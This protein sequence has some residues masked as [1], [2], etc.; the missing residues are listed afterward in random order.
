[1][2]RSPLRPTENRRDWLLPILSLFTVTF[3]VYR[4]FDIRMLYGYA[5]L[6]LILGVHV[7][8][9][10]WDD[11]A[12]AL[13]PIRMALV[14]LALAVLVNFLRPDSHHNSDSLSFII[15]MVICCGFAVLSR[16]T[17]KLARITLWV[18]FAGAVG[19][20]AFIH[21]FQLNPWYFWNWFMMKVSD[22]AA[23]YTAYYIPKGYSFTLG[24]CT[25]TDYTLFLGLAVC[26]AYLVCGRKFDW[27]SAV[28]AGL[29][30]VFFYSILIVGRRGELLGAAACLAILVLALCNKKQ[31]RVLIVGGIIAAA[32]GF[33]AVV[34]LMPWL[35]QI[36]ALHRYVW[37]VEWMLKGYDITSGRTELYALAW[38]AFLANPLF[39]LGW[40]NFYT[41]I[42]ESFQSLHGQNIVEDVHNIYLQFLAE[43]GIVGTPFLIAPLFYI[44]WQVVRQFSRL[45]GCA[46]EL[47]TARMFCTVSFLIQ[48]FLLVMGLIDPT[49]QKI[50]FWCFYGIAVLLQCT[51][52]ELEGH[53]S[54][55]PASR[56]LHKLIRFCAPP[57][58]LVWNWAAKLLTKLRTHSKK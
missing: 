52:L 36:P 35:K 26:C 24:G 4:D 17:E 40:D 53:T 31:R 33:A 10:L 34:A 37:T 56:W 5:L 16:P 47:R 20:T 29:G 38:R 28:A 13:D 55:D 27:K 12:P 44:Y 25:Q 14:L 32:V 22:T 6:A 57:F 9:R 15:S 45:K 1:M 43:T 30:A 18:C 8:R 42:P 46:A 54:D 3:F 49:F 51:A 7:L 41:V 19:I 39:G 50:V 23:N 2:T 21:F 58:V 11:R 48:S